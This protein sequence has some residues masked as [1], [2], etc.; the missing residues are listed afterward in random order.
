MRTTKPT[1]LVI[2]SEDETDDTRN[3][4]E[5]AGIQVSYAELAAIPF[6]GSCQKESLLS[7]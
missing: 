6:N 4:L 3:G 2:W 5:I 7:A 1:T